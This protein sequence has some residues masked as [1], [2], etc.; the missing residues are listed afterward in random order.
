MINCQFI[1]DESTGRAYIRALADIPE[2]AE[3]F[4]EYGPDY[5][6]CH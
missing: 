1:A 2:G 4:V 6:A 3:L 5:W